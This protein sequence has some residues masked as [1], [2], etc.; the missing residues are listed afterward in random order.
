M[1]YSLVVVLVALLE[2]SKGISMVA[3]MVERKVA[4]SENLLA[5]WM[6]E[7]WVVAKEYLMVYRLAAEKASQTAAGLV[8]SM[9]GLLGRKT[10]S[11]VEK[12]HPELNIKLKEKKRKREITCGRQNWLS[13]RLTCRNHDG[14]CRWLS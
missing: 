13:R 8:A 3:S 4:L 6:V 10:I 5:V 9:V 2:D 1:V 14:L 7:W 11:S 12:S